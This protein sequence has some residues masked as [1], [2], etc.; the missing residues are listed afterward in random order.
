MR[1]LRV[2]L[3]SM[4]ETSLVIVRS[5]VSITKEIYREKSAL[6]YRGTKPDSVGFQC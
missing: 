2:E 3:F 1:C 6:A 5:L 4:A